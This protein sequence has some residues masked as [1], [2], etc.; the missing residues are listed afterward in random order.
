MT[1]RDI[2]LQEIATSSD[3]VLAEAIDFIRFLKAKSVTNSRNDQESSAP[4]ENPHSEQFDDPK[5]EFSAF[6]DDLKQLP[7]RRA[8]LL[9]QEA[10]TSLNSLEHGKEMIWKNVFAL[11]KKLALSRSFSTNHVLTGYESL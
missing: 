9:R 6:L 7:L 8:E 10:K 3:E 5:A 11:C 1:Y 2:L 4:V